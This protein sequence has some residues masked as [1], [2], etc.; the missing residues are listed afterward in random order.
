[1][2][3]KCCHSAGKWGPCPPQWKSGGTCRKESG[4]ARNNAEAPDPGAPS[5]LPAALAATVMLEGSWRCPESGGWK[6]R[7]PRSWSLSKDG[8]PPPGLQHLALEQAWG[9]LPE[10]QP[11]AWC[12]LGPQKN[13]PAGDPPCPGRSLCCRGGGVFLLVSRK[14][15][16][17]RGQGSC[18]TM[19]SDSARHAP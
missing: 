9:H 6:E 12:V 11:R 1:M 10:Q 17:R 19:T 7:A 13:G 2:I 3:P 5:F 4:A 8:A 15:R 16:V 18:A 14:P